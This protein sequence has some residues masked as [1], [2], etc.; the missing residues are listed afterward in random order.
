MLLQFHLAPIELKFEN[1]IYATARWLTKQQVDWVN[2]S[3][4]LQ[5]KYRSRK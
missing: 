1:R 2:Y 5:G 4:N 3:E